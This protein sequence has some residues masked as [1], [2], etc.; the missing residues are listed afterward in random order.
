MSETRI[1]GVCGRLNPPSTDRCPCGYDLPPAS[2]EPVDP[3]AENVRKL[4]TWLAA[5]P[6]IAVAVGLSG[7]GL[8]QMGRVSTA[9]GA[10]PSGKRASAGAMKCVEVYGMTMNTSEFYV[11]EGRQF[12]SPKSGPRE[13]STVLRGMA[14][15]NCEGPVKGVKVNLKVKD[16]KGKH[17]S[18][19]V[20]VGDLQVG[21]AKAFERAW[22]ARV[23]DYEVGEVK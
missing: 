12:T 2:I 6:A 14:R 3:G 9:V 15:N 17:G 11:R 21:E 16:D 8:F 7:Y 1:C 10:G 4:P 23:T 19:W 20:P 5:L 13:L 22:M 18:S